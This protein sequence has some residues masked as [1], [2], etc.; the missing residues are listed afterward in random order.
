VVAIK[1][2]AFTEGQARL[3]ARYT[4]TVVLALDSDFAGQNASRRGI[5]ILEEAGFEIKVVKLGKFK[6]PDEAA[7]GNPEFYKEEIKSAVPIWDF[8]IDSVIAK[9][10][11]ESAPGKEKISKELTPI[12]AGIENKIVQDH[13]V[14][15][16]AALLEVSIEAVEEEVEKS[17]PDREQ[18]EP[19]MKKAEDVTQKPRR[20]LLE[21]TLI[22]MILK[23]KPN[24]LENPKILGLIKTKYAK[25]ILEEFASFAKSGAEINLANF[26]KFLP[27]ELFEKFSMIVFSINEIEEKEIKSEIN[28]VYAEL[29]GEVIKTKMRVVES[30]KE[31]SKLQKLLKDFNSAEFER[32]IT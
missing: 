10:D 20:E 21:E 18:S 32:I 5:K 22:A 27:K 30:S 14:K 9:Y 11:P 31:Y 8:I 12:L 6:D 19:D 23:E 13:Y 1:G 24:L 28:K 3:L 16:L 2:S 25:R 4:K 29:W 7:K 26:S 15:K 17:E